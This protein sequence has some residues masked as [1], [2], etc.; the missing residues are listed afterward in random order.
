MTATLT[1]PPVR[2]APFAPPPVIPPRRLTLPMPGDEDA[3][4]DAEM[5]ARYEEEERLRAGA[6]CEMGCD[7]PEGPL[8][9]DGCRW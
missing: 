7:W 5:C 8:A 4:R 3:D 9:P 2:T 6:E 1:R